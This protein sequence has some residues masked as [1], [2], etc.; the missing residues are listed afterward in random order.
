MQKVVT[1]GSSRYE[2]RCDEHYHARC[3]RCGEVH[4]IDASND[5]KQKLSTLP[6]NGFQA[7]RAVIEF[8]G[9]CD[10]CTPN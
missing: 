10:H 7:E 5:L 6:L 1:D 9:V 8:R 3:T 2:A 4:D